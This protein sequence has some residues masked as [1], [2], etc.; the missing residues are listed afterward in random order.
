M[1]TAESVGGMNLFDAARAAGITFTAEILP[2]GKCVEANGM[3]LHY[4]DWGNP[5]KPK[6]LLLHALFLPPSP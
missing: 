2:A 6:M 1:T 3:R 5:N 4:L